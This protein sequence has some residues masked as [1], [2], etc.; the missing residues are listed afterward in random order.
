M[1]FVRKNKGS[2]VRVDSTVYVGEKGYTFWDVGTGKS[3]LSD[4]I[5]PGGLPIDGD[6]G[7][8]GTSD[9]SLL[10]NRAI[11]DQHP[12]N[13]VTGLEPELTD[14][15]TDITNI[16]VDLVNNVYTDDGWF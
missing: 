12:I 6:G 3:R 7:G 14:I 16:E 5:T 1:A 8:P 10:I 4:G 9:H 15:N 11:P 13:S 2:L